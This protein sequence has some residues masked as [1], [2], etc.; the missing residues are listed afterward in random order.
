MKK[1]SL[2]L[3]LSLLVFSGS[4][5]TIAYSTRKDLAAK[6]GDTIAAAREVMVVKRSKTQMMMKSGGDFKITSVK[7]S[8]N[9]SFR[10]R[11]HAVWVDGIFYVNCRKLKMNKL[12]FGNFYAQAMWVGDKIYFSAYPLGAASRSLSKDD[13]V[14]MGEF[15][16]AIN[17]ST[18]AAKRVVY[19]LD[20]HTGIV[21]FV[22]REKMR[23][24]LE[25]YPLLQE[26]F[27][28]ETSEEVHVIGKYLREIAKEF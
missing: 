19:E 16:D 8:L 17:K 26:S 15:G 7:E 18:Y 14:Q 4:A 6:K 27:A 20:P 13:E 1:Y 23:S 5:Q 11:Y 24:M 9:R 2:L 25:P 3:L 22:G 21:T 12:W 28:K 10:T